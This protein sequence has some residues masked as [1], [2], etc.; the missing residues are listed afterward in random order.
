M[1]SLVVM[2]TSHCEIVCPLIV[3]IISLLHC[4]GDMVCVVHSVSVCVCSVMYVSQYVCLCVLLCIKF[5]PSYLSMKHNS[6]CL[7]FIYP[8]AVKLE[9]G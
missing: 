6:Q 8:A 1:A 4:D 2:C 5:I 9:L 7:Q 3:H